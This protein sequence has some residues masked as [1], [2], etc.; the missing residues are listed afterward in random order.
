MQ[1]SGNETVLLPILI[2]QSVHLS[3]DPVACGYGSCE[4]E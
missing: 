1:D 2:G 3:E 4:F